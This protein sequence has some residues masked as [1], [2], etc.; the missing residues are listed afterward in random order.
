MN[1]EQTTKERLLS[2]IHYKQLN[3]S[4]FQRIIGVS[5][6][7]V[8]NTGKIGAKTLRRI[9][10]KFPELNTYWLNDGIGEMIKPVTATSSK[11][12][13]ESKNEGT[14][15]GINYVPVVDL[16]TR[17]ETSIATSIDN[18]VRRIASPVQNAYVAFVIA[19][20]CMQPSISNGSYALAIDCNAKGFIEWGKTYIVER[21]HDVVV[22]KLF[23]TGS[24]K[25]VRGIAINNN[26]PDVEIPVKEITSLWKVTCIITV[27]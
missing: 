4:E 19:D 12:K 5:G 26:Y 20:D 9:G 25:C 13:F 6:S 14:P 11:S 15:K 10:E 3:N 16:L 2:F 1:T 8:Q 7:Y 22:R 21:G 24:T 18:C 23:P 27:V 17:C